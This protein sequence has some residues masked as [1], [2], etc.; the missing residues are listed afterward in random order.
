[1]AKSLFFLWSGTSFY[2]DI[3]SRLLLFAVELR[4]TL[5]CNRFVRSDSLPPRREKLRDVDRVDAVI[6]AEM[7][8]GADIRESHADI[9][10]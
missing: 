4:I 9:D 7:L 5:L 1:M 8:L 6:D 10:D 3:P 2:V